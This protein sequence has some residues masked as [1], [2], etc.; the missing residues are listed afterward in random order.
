VLAVAFLGIP[1]GVLSIALVVTIQC[2]VFSDGGFAVLGANIL[3]MAVIGAGIGG[4]F[5]AYF[6]KKFNSRSPQYAAG[7]GFAAWLSVMTAALAVSV[8]LAASG[9]IAFSKVAGAMLGTHA[10]IGI[11]EALIT[12]A[13]CFALSTEPVASSRKRSIVVPLAASGMIAAVLSPFAS[14]FPDG[15]E[16]VAEKYNFLHDAAPSFVSPMPDYSV[17]FVSNEML[18]TSVAGLAGVLITFIAAWF[19][20]KLLGVDSRMETI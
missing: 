14:G 18:S 19:I 1:F 2:M 17:S 3:N 20:A 6:A 4:F 11:G 10:L 16:W 13:V 9:T 8:E 5:N 12:V 15:L 7:L